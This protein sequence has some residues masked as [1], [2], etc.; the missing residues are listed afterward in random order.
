MNLKS[1]VRENNYLKILVYCQF[2]M[3]YPEMQNQYFLFARYQNYL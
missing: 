3:G 1:T 2:A